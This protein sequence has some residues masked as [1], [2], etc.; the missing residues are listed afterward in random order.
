MFLAESLQAVAVAYASNRL[1]PDED[2]GVTI[3]SVLLWKAFDNCTDCTVTPTHPAIAQ[4]VL[5]H[6]SIQT[7]LDIYSHVTTEATLQATSALAQA[8]RQRM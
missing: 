4:C 7:T 6:S 3:Q 2:L 8:L 1:W 5:G